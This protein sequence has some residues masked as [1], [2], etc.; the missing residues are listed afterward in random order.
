MKLSG[1]ISE[2]IA[3]PVSYLD[4][5]HLTIDCKDKLEFVNKVFWMCYLTKKDFKK[6]AGLTTSAEYLRIRMDVHILYRTTKIKNLL[7]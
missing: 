4:I 7:K 6:Y 1:Y 3:D 5:A 2:I